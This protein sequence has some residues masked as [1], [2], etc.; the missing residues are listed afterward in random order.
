MMTNNDKIKSFRLLTQEVT[1]L[2]F[3]YSTDYENPQIV[4]N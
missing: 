4:F 2:L 3:N 1:R